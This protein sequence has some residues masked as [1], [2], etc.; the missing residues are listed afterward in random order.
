[1]A[2]APRRDLRVCDSF[3]PLVE[4]RLAKSRPR[5]MRVRIDEAGQ[6]GLAAPV[7]DDLALRGRVAVAR[8]VLVVRA[9][10]RE[11]LALDPDRGTRDADDPSLLRAGARNDAGRRGE[12]VEMSD[13][14][15]AIGHAPDL[16]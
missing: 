3:Q 1:D 16:V 13:R 5:K 4:L 14:E 10:E 9:H 12:A 6:R 15:N 8:G 2:P 11:Q 7:H